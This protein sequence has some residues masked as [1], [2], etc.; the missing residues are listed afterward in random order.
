MAVNPTKGK[1]LTN[2]RAAGSDEKIQLTP[3]RELT[4]ERGLEVMVEDEYLE[5][6][7]KSIRLR[8]QILDETER[9]KKQRKA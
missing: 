4:L 8:K 5:V 9:R 3:S 7:P 6:T 2:M 1:E